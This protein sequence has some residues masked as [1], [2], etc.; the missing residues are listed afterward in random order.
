MIRRIS[1]LAI[2]AVLGITG[3]RRL[4]RAAKSLLPAG[5][6]LVP[7]SRR[8]A[9]ADRPGG[10]RDA[11]PVPELRH[12]SAMSAPAWRSTWTGTAI[13]ESALRR[14]RQYPRRSARLASR[15]EPQAAA[16]TLRMAVDG[17]GRDR[18]PFP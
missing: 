5:D 18:P 4:T 6:A 7:L 3:Y 1:W 12:S 15:R 16:T 14:L 10:P 2:G 17:V 13:Y 8:T 9:G 11:A